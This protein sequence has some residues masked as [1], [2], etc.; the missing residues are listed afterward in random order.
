MTVPAYGL[1][2]M[3]P[4]DVS[5]ESSAQPRTI[6]DSKPPPRASSGEGRVQRSNTGALGHR[7]RVQRTRQ[8]ARS[9]ERARFRCSNGLLRAFG[10][11]MLGVERV[12][13]RDEIS[14]LGGERGI[15]KGG[16]IG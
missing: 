4:S 14:E 12:A 6:V 13:P 8:Y 15:G 2:P 5:S 16:A 1:T 11:A 7:R 10:D 3:Q 9:D